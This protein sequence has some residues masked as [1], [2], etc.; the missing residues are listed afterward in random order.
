VQLQGRRARPYRAAECTHLRPSRPAAQVAIQP[1]QCTASAR[2]LRTA[3]VEADAHCSRDLLRV[4]RLKCRLRTACGHVR[5]NSARGAAYGRLC[6]YRPGG[7]FTVPTL[8]TRSIS[9][10]SAVACCG[11]AQHWPVTRR[12]PHQDPDL[13]LFGPVRQWPRTALRMLPLASQAAALYSSAA[14]Q[15]VLHSMQCN[16]HQ[17]RCRPGGS[18]VGGRRCARDRVLCRS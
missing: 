12:M 3:G 6:T 18:E 11:G 8:R 17:A 5:G 2:R 7:C 14:A 1:L 10:A 13:L 15:L 4:C 9:T 16:M